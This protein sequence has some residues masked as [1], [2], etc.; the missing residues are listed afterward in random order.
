MVLVV[1]LTAGINGT[2]YV[3]DGTRDD[4]VGIDTDTAGING[5]NYVTDG[6]GTNYV[7]DGTR[8]DTVGIDTDTAGINGTD[9]DT[10]CGNN[11][12]TLCCPGWQA[13]GTSNTSRR[14]IRG[15]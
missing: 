15:W 1:I 3:T 6:N 11:I 5:T 12:P 8:G 2:N 4:T 14:R 10:I 7:T 13:C 9:Y